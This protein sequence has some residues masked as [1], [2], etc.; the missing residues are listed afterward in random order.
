MIATESATDL[1]GDGPFFG[2]LLPFPAVPRNDRNATHK[3]TLG[4]GD[5]RSPAP[6]RARP[7]LHSPREPR[8]VRKSSCGRRS[9]KS[10]SGNTVE[11][12]DEP[13]GDFRRNPKGRAAFGRLPCRLSLVDVQSI[14]LLAPG[15]RVVDLKLPRFRWHSRLGTSNPKPHEIQ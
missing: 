10:V 7:C 6:G 5:S 13:E 12:F 8:C 1:P 9:A 4:I 2:E 11:R 3:P 15:T 14:A